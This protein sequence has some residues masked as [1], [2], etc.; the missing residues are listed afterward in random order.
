MLY[1]VKK[2]IGEVSARYIASLSELL[3]DETS[4]ETDDISSIIYDATTDSARAMNE[5]DLLALAKTK[6]ISS[7]KQACTTAIQSGFTSSA[8]GS[9]HTYDS[10]LPTDQTNI[11]GAMVA[12]LS[13]ASIPFTCTDSNGYKEQRLHTAAQLQQ[14]FQAG[15]QHIVVNKSRYDT[16]KK[17]VEQATTVEDVNEVSW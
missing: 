1:A 11:I 15:M 3:P 5:S 16:L 10:E 12:S 6:K 17:Q 2:Q 13:G 8:L 9:A 7:L 14:V 4:I